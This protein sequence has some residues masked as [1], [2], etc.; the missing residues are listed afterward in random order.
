MQILFLQEPALLAVGRLIGGIGS[1]VGAGAVT[2]YIQEISPTNVRGLL[3]SFQAI[4]N[5]LTTL[6][7]MILG[8][9]TV[10]GSVALL[11]Y[12]MGIGILPGFLKL[13]LLLCPETPKY[14]LLKK[15]KVDDARNA[16]MFYH[17]PEVNVE[18][19]LAE[20]RKEGELDNEKLE[21]D[22]GTDTKAEES[23]KLIQIMKTPHLRKGLLLGSVAFAGLAST[24][25]IP[26]M[27]Y[28]TFLL[29]S[30]DVQNNVALLVGILMGA[31]FVLT[32]IVSLALVEI[33]GRKKLLMIG[34]IA[35]MF[36]L[37]LLMVCFMVNTPSGW[38]GYLACVVIVS[39]V[40]LF[41]VGPGT[42]PWYLTSELLPSSVRS[43]AQCFTLVV[44]VLF[45]FGLSFAFLPL[46]AVWGG[47]SF[48]ALFI[49]PTIIFAVYLY[50]ELPETKNREISDVVSELKNKSK[51][52][53]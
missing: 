31:C 13:F 8:L 7:G 6:L 36:M 18:V 23:W 5:N 33:S 9:P 12:L 28:S 40:A 30:L 51:K 48:L 42:I 47:Y 27:E 26:L 44:F 17:G 52:V 50:I 45:N 41:G 4:S 32:S 16:V 38:P 46:F 19:V 37:I 14:L 24:G 43:T 11:P 25:V 2:L 29:L 3:S 49:I 35:N 34:F 10:L 1:G 22:N 15:D 20:I 39:N 21:F 53:K